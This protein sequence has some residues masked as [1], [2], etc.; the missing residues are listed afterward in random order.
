MRLQA[1]L[2]RRQ[3]LGPRDIPVAARAL[4]RLTGRAVGTVTNLRAR[5][6]TLTQGAAFE[7]AHRDLRDGMTQL[8]AIRDEIKSG[9]DPLRPLPRRRPAPAATGSPPGA[10]DSPPPPPRPPS[11]S[12]VGESLPPR[13]AARPWSEGAPAGGDRYSF[14]FLPISAAALGRGSAGGGQAAGSPRCGSDI[15]EDVEAEA[16]LAA[17]AVRLTSTPGALDAAYSS[18]QSRPDR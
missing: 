13:G 10:G 6:E 5:A 17:E 12:S 18:L 15:L 1:W 4:G 14:P 11:Q 2:T 9:F 8:S 7:E 3:L 16:A